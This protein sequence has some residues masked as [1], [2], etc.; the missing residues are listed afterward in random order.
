MTSGDYQA[1]FNQY[2][3]EGY[4]LREV[5]GYGANGQPH[6]AAIFEKSG[7][8]AWIARHGMSSSVYQA[9][10]NDRV[11]E[12]YRLVEVSGYT[13][14]GEPHYAA[15]F[16]KSAGAAWVARHGMSSSQYQ[17]EFTKRVSEGYRLRQ[18]CGYAVGNEAQYAAIFDKSAGPAWIARH[19][20][21]SAAYQAE[22]NARVKEGY[23]LRQI[24]GYAVGN[25]ARYAAIFD[26]TSG[27]AWVSYHGMTASSYQ[28]QFTK[29]VSEGYRLASV[30]GY[31]VAGN[32]LYAALWIRQTPQ[33]LN[34][35]KNPGFE[36]AGAA[37]TVLTGSP[38]GGLSAAPYWTT[39]NNV[40]GL[41]TTEILPSTRPGG[42]KQMLHVSTQAGSDGIVQVFGE[43]DKGPAKTMSGV[44]VFVLHGTVCLGTGNG[45]N[46][47]IDAVS[48]TQGQWEYVEGP[49]GVSPAN[50]FVVYAKSLEG[51]SF[52]VDDASVVAA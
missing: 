18:V 49:N 48:T 5:N 27:P 20:M 38:I 33:G 50:E 19:D 31:V 43:S 7:G 21:D 25:E 11:K 37:P 47:H 28:Q 52:Y 29:L 14:N 42:S 46:T 40:S 9:E 24:S 45:G 16:D 44:W 10:F 32:T 6:Y 39:W 8:P 41:T 30:S 12:G 13:I 2:V 36:E 26:K 17:Q 35:L 23:R 4:R 1:K 15:I 34:L 22:F 3:G 51:A